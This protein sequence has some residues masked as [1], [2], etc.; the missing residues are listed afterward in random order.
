MKKLLTIIACTMPMVLASPL[1]AQ[2]KNASS[3]KTDP[4][5]ASAN[6]SSASKSGTSKSDM[7]SPDKDAGNPTQGGAAEK[8]PVP[9]AQ[10]PDST[11]PVNT[12]PTAVPGI[13]N[14]DSTAKPAMK[15]EK[16]GIDK[17]QKNISGVSV[18][19]SIMGKSVQNEAGDKIGDISDV[20]LATDGQVA[21][22]IV[23][24]GGFLGMG[25]HNVAIPYDKIK[26]N[27]DKL[28][29]PG[30]TKDQLKAL[31]KVDVKK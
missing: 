3:T 13:P 7:S 31:P 1:Y 19:N 28:V 26:Q 27:G 16:A 30:Y 11:A 6:G 10:S 12:A 15:N 8:S 22:F 14:A 20:V 5:A 2:D 4:A 9:A 21:Y 17:Q 18:K 23:G 24:A 29:L 25:E